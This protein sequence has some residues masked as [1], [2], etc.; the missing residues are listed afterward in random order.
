MV[1]HLFGQ[2]NPT[3]GGVLSHAKCLLHQLRLKARADSVLHSVRGGHFA[4]EYR[5]TLSQDCD[6]SQTAGVELKILQSYRNKTQGD[7]GRLLQ[8]NCQ[9]TVGQLIA[10]EPRLMI[11][12]PKGHLQSAK[13]AANLPEI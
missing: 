10:S 2:N 5:Y 12:K 8:T 11:M 6:H 9:I 3:A 1:V 7:S 4:T 13:L